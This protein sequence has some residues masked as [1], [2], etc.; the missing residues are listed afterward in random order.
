[1]KR[2]KRLADILVNYSLKIKKGNLSKN[3]YLESI[4]LA[5]LMGIDGS[6]DE[7]RHQFLKKLRKLDIRKKPGT[8]G[9]KAKKFHLGDVLNELSHHVIDEIE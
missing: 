5:N 3:S 8:Q 4:D 1:M 9:G 2:T 6:D 7:Q